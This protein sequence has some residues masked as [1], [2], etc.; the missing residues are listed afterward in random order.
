MRT[1]L[2]RGVFTAG[3]PVPQR[4]KHRYRPGTLALKEIK[5][6]QRSTDLLLLKLPFS[7]LVSAASFALFFASIKKTIIPSGAIARW[8]AVSFALHTDQPSTGDLDFIPSDG[9]LL[10]RSAKSPSRWYRQANCCAGNRKRSRRSKR[11]PRRSWCI[12]SKTR[13]CAPSTRNG[14]PLCRRTSSS[15]GGSEGLGEGW[16]DGVTWIWRRAVCGLLE[17]LG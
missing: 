12:C 4:K 9:S 16:D 5:R 6:Y 2:S 8:A 15:R 1:R 14:S 13:I 11:P 17:A 3:D 10:V 7:R